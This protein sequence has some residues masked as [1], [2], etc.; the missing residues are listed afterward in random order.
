MQFSLAYLKNNF[1]NFCHERKEQLKFC[2]LMLVLLSFMK[3][4]SVWIHL[5]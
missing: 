5:F 4:P 2:K 1:E 3:V